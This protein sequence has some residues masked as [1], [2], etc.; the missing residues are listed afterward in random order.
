V[1]IG[2]LSEVLE[3]P[4]LASSKTSVSLGVDGSSKGGLGCGTSKKPKAAERLLRQDEIPEQ[5]TSRPHQ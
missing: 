1:C 4:R 2:M 5:D 3:S